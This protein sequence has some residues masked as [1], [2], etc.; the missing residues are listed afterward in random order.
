MLSG[1]IVNYRCTALLIEDGLTIKY[2]FTALSYMGGLTIKYRCTAVLYSDEGGFIIK[3]RYIAVSY[4]LGECLCHKIR[5]VKSC[6]LSHSPYIYIDM[7]TTHDLCAF[8]MK[9][10]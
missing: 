10:L 5:L 1:L 3:Y 9:L 2:N 8:V 4:K 7:L 6:G